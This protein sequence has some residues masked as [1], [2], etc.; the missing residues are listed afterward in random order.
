MEDNKVVAAEEKLE[1]P[2]I[3]YKNLIILFFLFVIATLTVLSNNEIFVVSFQKKKAIKFEYV[4]IIIGMVLFL[5]VIGWFLIILS[6]A[7]HENQLLGFTNGKF[8]GIIFL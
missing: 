1:N 8:R 2:L 4:I 5:M 3:K 6:L 7:S